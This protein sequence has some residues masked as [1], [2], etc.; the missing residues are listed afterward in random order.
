LLGALSGDVVINPN[1]DGYGGTGVVQLGATAHPDNLIYLQY[2]SD[3]SA[4]TSTNYYGFSHALAFISLSKTNR[5]P[6]Y[7]GILGFC[8]NDTAGRTETGEI[9]IYAR[10]PHWFEPAAG[11]TLNPTNPAIPGVLVSD[12]STNGV[13]NNYRVVSSAYIAATNGFA[14]YSTTA[15]APIAATG[16]TN[17]WSTNNANVRVT[18]TGQTIT[19][20]NRSNA[21]VD[22]LTSFT[23][24]V[25]L[26]IQPGWAITA[27][28]GLSGTAW[29]Y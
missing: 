23:G 24:T 21:T 13:F 22:T 16:W 25:V 7:P 1:Y 6:H 12:F 28:S 20:K 9:R 19:I 5:A 27:A 2:A 17:I 29:S 3:P 11:T 18:G 26:P 10:V 8:A 4:A 15:P 14:S